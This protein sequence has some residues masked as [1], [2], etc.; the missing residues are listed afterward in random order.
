MLQTLQP[1][2]GSERS[3]SL[4]ALKDRVSR[5]MNDENSSSIQ[6]KT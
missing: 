4:P 1:L 6:R 5:E 3:L 2:F